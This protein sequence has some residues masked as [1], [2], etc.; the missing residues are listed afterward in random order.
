MLL[1][2]VLCGFALTE[3]YQ[4][5]ALDLLNLNALLFPAA[6]LKVAAT[7]LAMMGM[8]PDSARVR[9]CGG[10]CMPPGPR[11]CPATATASAAPFQL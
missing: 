10:R 9:A 7:L 1:S 2:M 11:P 3:P 6:A 5:T 4:G 8:H